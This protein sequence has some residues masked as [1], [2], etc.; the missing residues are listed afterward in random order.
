MFIMELDEVEF[1][2]WN[3]DSV[4]WTLVGPMMQFL[5]DEGCWENVLKGKEWEQ[6]GTKKGWDQR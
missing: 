5:S 2:I 6:M 4:G 1:G 3:N